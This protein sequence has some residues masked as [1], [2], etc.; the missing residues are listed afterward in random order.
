MQPLHHWNSWTEEQATSGQ[1]GHEDPLNMEIAAF[2]LCLGTHAMPKWQI[3][4]RSSAGLCL[5]NIAQEQHHH[6]VVRGHRLATL[7][8]TDVHSGHSSSDP[9]APP[10]RKIEP[11]WLASTSTWLGPA[12][13]AS[14]SIWGSNCCMQWHCTLPKWLSPKKSVRTMLILNEAA[15]KQQNMSGTSKRNSQTQKS[16]RNG[17]FPKIGDPK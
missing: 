10:L 16:A 1:F 13:A 12:A 14:G 3:F 2:G 4:R 7:S 15:T 9:Q 17:G 5:G 6:H 11:N 8:A